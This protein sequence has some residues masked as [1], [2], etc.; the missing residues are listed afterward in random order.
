MVKI[1]ASRFVLWAC[2]PERSAAKLK[3]PHPLARVRRERILPEAVED[4][5]R[6]MAEILAAYG[7]ISFVESAVFIDVWKTRMLFLQ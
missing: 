3:D 7:E 4:I 5:L 1:N 2:H 6:Q